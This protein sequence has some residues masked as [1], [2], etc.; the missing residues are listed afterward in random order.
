MALVHGI[1]ASRFAELVHAA[2]ESERSQASAARRLGISTSYVSKVLRNEQEPAVHESTL[3][4]VG[5]RLGLARAD[6]QKVN[7]GQSPHEWAREV[8]KTLDAQPT[9]A[10]T[11][12]G[13]SIRAAREAVGMSQAE[14]ARRAG[15][16]VVTVWRWETGAMSPSI[17]H[18][19]VL[20]TI[21]V[22]FEWLDASKAP[23][24]L[25]DAVTR[26]LASKLGVSPGYV[27]KFEQV[28]R[29]IGFDAGALARGVRAE[30]LRTSE[31][32]ETQL[33]ARILDAYQAKGLTRT[34]FARAIGVKPNSVWR[35]EQGESRP[36]PDTLAKIADVTGRS[37]E[38]LLVGER[39]ER[40]D[41][42]APPSVYDL[43]RRMDARE[44]RAFRAWVLA[45][46]DEGPDAA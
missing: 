24:P 25:G 11:P 23:S 45:W 33:G 38:W 16:S 12:L 19:Q 1:E 7:P 43:V 29:R 37:L 14:L 27:S 13:D 34:A 10:T 35:Y 36:R 41:I 2:V 3:V 26:A 5:D 44:L 15:V 18:A 20:A 32:S 6:W 40:V 30:G 4:S 22:P 17:A 46:T 39:G 21:G 9:G 8:L 28:E 31:R 42:A